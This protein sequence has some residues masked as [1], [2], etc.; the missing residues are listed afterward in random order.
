MDTWKIWIQQRIFKWFYLV[1]ALGFMTAGLD[2]F[3][4][5]ATEEGLSQGIIGM[6]EL[7]TGIMLIITGFFIVLFT[8]FVLKM[9]F[10]MWFPKV[11]TFRER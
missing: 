5:L 2:V 9:A 4:R 7:L 8:L 3:R 11:K 6:F 10:D 1:L